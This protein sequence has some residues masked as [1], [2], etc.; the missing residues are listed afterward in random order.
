M[1]PRQRLMLEEAWKALEDAGYGASKIKSSKIGMYVGVEDGDYGLLSGGKGSITSNNTAILAARLSYFLNLNGPNMAINTACSSGLVAA[2]QACQSLRNNECDTAIAAGVNML[3]SPTSYNGMYQAGM[4]SKDGRCYTFDKRANGMVPGE[5][6]AV[7]VLKRLSRAEADG[8]SIYAV[9]KG[10][11]VNYDGKTNGITAPSGVSQTSL[12]K[13]VYDRYKINPEEIEYI[14]AHGTGTKLGDPVE[15]NALNDAFKVYTQKQRYCALTSTKTNFG[16]S[17]AASGLVSLISLVQAL[18]N[19]TIPASLNCEHENDFINWDRSP[20]F[21]NKKN[22]AWPAKDGKIR[23][24]AVSAFGMSGTNAHMVLQGY[25]RKAV[26]EYTAPCYLLVLSAKTQE[27]LKEKIDDM[28]ALLEKTP[29][30]TQMSGISYTL[31]EGR[32]HFDFRFAAVV[33]GREDAIYLLRKAYGMEKLPNVFS[34]KV[35]RD[36][37]GSETI[38]QY[39]KELLKKVNYI[40]MTV[41]NT[42]KFF[43]LWRNY[44]ARGTKW[45]GQGFLEMSDPQ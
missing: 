34:G 33:K 37:K 22:R 43:M 23:M 39:S 2:H 27:A 41:V 5:A 7:L 35:A 1:D 28:A 40:R 17:L 29:G 36:F 44:I 45:I 20:F 42:E 19:E 26:S 25:E 8:D 18:K 4:L 24:G 14:V 3:L 13:S 9:I 30:D 12:L 32:H 10:S 6:V 38:K 21:V 31:L 11:G 15:I 16:H